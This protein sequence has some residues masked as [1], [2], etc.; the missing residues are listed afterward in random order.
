MAVMGTRLYYE[1]VERKWWWWC[2]IPIIWNNIPPMG[3]S[4]QKFPN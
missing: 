2:D 1:W 3:S 4:E